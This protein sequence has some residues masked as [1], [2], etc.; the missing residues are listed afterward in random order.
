MGSR[1]SGMTLLEMMVALAII[2]LI[3]AVTVPFVVRDKGTVAMRAAARQIAGMLREARSNA[4]VH[5]RIELFSADAAEGSFALAHRAVHHLPRG[6][7]MTLTTTAEQARSAT[8][9]TIRFYPDGTSTG[10]GL[11]LR[12]N[13][14]DTQV[15]VDW[16][17][18]RTRIVDEQRARDKTTR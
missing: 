16:L 18:G 1:Q 6:V 4:V 14:H 10:G 7:E 9:G 11:E 17:T 8:A 12:Q 3:T 5:N 13:G 2:G 15:L